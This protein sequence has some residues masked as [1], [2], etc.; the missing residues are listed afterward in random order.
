MPRP[1]TL[2]SLLAALMLLACT[3]P[4]AP[5]AAGG[6]S[7]TFVLTAL[8]DGT[9]VIGA[10]SVAPVAPPATPAPAARPAPTGE[11]GAGPASGPTPVPT[12]SYYVRPGHGSGGSGGG[13]APADP[14]TPTPTP[15]PATGLDFAPEAGGFSEP[16]APEAAAVRP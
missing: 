13:G 5:Q 16:A 1:I 11:P 6:W 10:A 8:A 7:G 9:P 2:A 3:P 15:T 4:D 12:A 14:P